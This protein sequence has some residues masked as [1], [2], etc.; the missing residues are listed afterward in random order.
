MEQVARTD[1]TILLRLADGESARSPAG[2][3]S[4]LLRNQW[5]GPRGPAARGAGAP[6]GVL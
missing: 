6:Q 2:A 4:E 3:V 1:A 5:A